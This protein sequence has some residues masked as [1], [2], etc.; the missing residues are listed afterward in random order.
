MESVRNGSHAFYDIRLSNGDAGRIQIDAHN[1]ADVLVKV[2]KYTAETNIWAEGLVN[3][4]SS[5]NFSYHQ[6]EHFLD[7]G[8][9]ISV[10]DP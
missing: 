9:D 5:A 7:D 8:F 1:A 6:Y 3:R 4:A 2:Y 10:D